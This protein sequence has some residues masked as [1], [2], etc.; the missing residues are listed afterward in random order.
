MNCSGSGR[1]PKKH[2]RRN[3]PDKGL[4]STCT[5]NISPDGH[6]NSAAMALALGRP[7]FMTDGIVT[8]K[9]IKVDGETFTIDAQ[10]A[11]RYFEGRFAAFQQAVPRCSSSTRPSLSMSMTMCRA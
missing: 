7:V 10:A 9:I 2:R 3:M 1:P 11:D 4:C 6:M 5:Y 8:R